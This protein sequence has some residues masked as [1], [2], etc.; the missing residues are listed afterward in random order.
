MPGSGRGAMKNHSPVGESLGWRGRDR[1]PSPPLLGFFGRV[2]KWGFLLSASTAAS[3][4]DRTVPAG[5]PLCFSFLPSLFFSPLPY[6]PQNWPPPPTYS[7]LELDELVALRTRCTP[8]RFPLRCPDGV[9]VARTRFP[10]GRLGGG[11]YISHGRST[12]HAIQGGGLPWDRSALVA[13]RGGR[14]CS[15]S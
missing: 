14:P 5:V 2:F 15:V 1:V 6:P 9:D 3:C 13:L 11:G 8:I 4:A 12:A 7:P 10:C